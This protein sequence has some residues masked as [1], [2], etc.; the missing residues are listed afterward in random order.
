MQ[1]LHTLSSSRGLALGLVAA[2]AAT[3]AAQAATLPT[4]ELMRAQARAQHLAHAAPDGRRI[5]TTPPVLAAFN[6]GTSVD[7][8]LANSGVPIGLTLTDDLSGVAYVYVEAH[9]PHGQVIEVQRTF[10]YADRKA[11]ATLGLML[12]SAAEPGDWQVTYLYAYDLAGNGLSLGQSALA[13]LGNTHFTVSN[14]A[15]DAIPPRLVRGRIL[16]PSFSISKYAKGVPRG[17]PLESPGVGIKVTDD[18]G[19]GSAGVRSAT[20]NFCMPDE[21]GDCYDYDFMLMADNASGL[22]GDATTDLV[23]GAD[24]DYFYSTP[25]PGTYALESLVL[26][27]F[28]GNTRTYTSTDFGGDTDFSKYFPTT[29]IVVTP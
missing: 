12:S 23:L 8:R 9:G 17:G 11:R 3:T 14:D 26:T 4:P 10:D 19:P 24:A 21:Y 7:A 13:A 27:D 6:A 20:M 1:R 18:G 25:T 16:T 5:D 29:T 28:A 2:V 22:P 15:F